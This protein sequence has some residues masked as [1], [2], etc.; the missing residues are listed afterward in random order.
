MANATASSDRRRQLFDPRVVARGDC[1]AVSGSV[2]IVGGGVDRTMVV[3]RG[4][5]SYDTALTLT[6]DA[7]RRA[8]STCRRTARSPP[9]ASCSRRV[10]E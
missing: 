5:L 9:S 8:R 4:R 10:R 7:T 3:V 6:E 2:T 1:V